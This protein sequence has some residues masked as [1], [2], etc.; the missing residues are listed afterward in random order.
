VAFLRE[1][2]ITHVLI[3]ALTVF[4]VITAFWAS[5]FIGLIAKVRRER[6]LF[7]TDANLSQE[8]V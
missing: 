2:G 7:G 8:S 3:H 6:S 1:L 4:V 5:P